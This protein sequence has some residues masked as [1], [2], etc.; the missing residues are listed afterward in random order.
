[1]EVLV[2][3]ASKHFTGPL[4]STSTSCAQQ[5][6]QSNVQA[7]VTLTQLLLPDMLR[8]CSGGITAPGQGNHRPRTLSTAIASWLRNRGNPSADGS[9]STGGSV[10]AQTGS[11]EHPTVTSDFNDLSKHRGGGG[12]I[13]FISSLG[14]AGPAPC[15]SVY[16]ASKA[17][18]SSF[19]Q[20]WYCVR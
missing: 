20:V 11:E 19:A 14:A 13:L 4:S 18:L 5:M 12:R 9:G 3:A 2:H 1:M 15:N 8:R 17:F 7:A 6:I 16:A 10:R